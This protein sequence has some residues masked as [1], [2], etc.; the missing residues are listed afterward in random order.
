[1]Q[2]GDDHGIELKT[3]GLV[4]GHHLQRTAER[5]GWR[6][7]FAGVGSQGVGIQLAGGDQAVD[8]REEGFDIAQ[9]FR[10][11]QTAR[12]AEHQPDAFQPASRVLAVAL[13]KRDVQHVAHM[14]KAFLAVFRE[15][16]DPGRIVHQLP[17]CRLLIVGRQRVQ[18]GQHQ[19]TPR[20]R[21]SASQ[22]T[23]SAR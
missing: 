18:V 4:N 14:P 7:Q 21:K 3:L 1:M 13:G 8:Q 19:A 5:V 16:S 9:G 20:A 11:F 10:R 15:A 2:A 22:C 6:V 23:R 12:P 17:D